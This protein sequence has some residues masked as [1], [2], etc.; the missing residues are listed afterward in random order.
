MLMQSLLLLFHSSQELFIGSVVAGLHGPDFGWVGRVL[1]FAMEIS[2]E[3]LKCFV[4][5]AHF[6]SL[7]LAQFLVIRF[8]DLLLFRAECLAE[9]RF[10]LGMA[11]F[12][13]PLP[14]HHFCQFR[15]FFRFILPPLVQLTQ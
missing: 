8:F 2:F 7:L 3:F 6:L 14:R 15:F 5:L 4:L 9:L 13:R 11:L 12:Q 10:F 1:Q